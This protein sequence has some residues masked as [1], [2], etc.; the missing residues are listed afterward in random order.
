M[1]SKSALIQISSHNG[2][3]II[4]SERRASGLSFLA[5]FEGES[6]TY[7]YLASQSFDGILAMTITGWTF[8]NTKDL[9]GDTV[10][11]NAT[12]QGDVSGSGYLLDP[13]PLP[14]PV[15]KNWMKCGGGAD[16][17]GG[18]L[19]WTTT[20]GQQG[21]SAIRGATMMCGVKRISWREIF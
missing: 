9:S 17:A 1:E 15:N 19:V 7:G 3:A 8:L 11:S 2:G 10:T 14:Y 4:E 13:N 16:E 12:T 5:A 21:V 6:S 20:A 18:S